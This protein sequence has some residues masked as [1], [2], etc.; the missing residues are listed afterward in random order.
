MTAFG[1]RM[2]NPQNNFQNDE[3][4]SSVKMSNTDKYFVK[5]SQF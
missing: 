1:G 4:N 2:V 3:I 5:I